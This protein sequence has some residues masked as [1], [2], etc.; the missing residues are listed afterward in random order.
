MDDHTTDMYLSE[1][2]ERL[3]ADAGDGPDWS[4][5]GAPA[6]GTSKTPGRRGGLLVGLAVGVVI[7]MTV[8]VVALSRTGGGTPV[9]ASA[10]EYVK[11]AWSQEAELACVGMDTHD[12]GGFDDATIEMWG[13]NA[14]GLVRIDAT[15]PDGMVERILLE[16]SVEE[17]RSEPLGTSHEGVGRS[18]T[19]FHVSACVT[20]DAD[21]TDS[22]SVAQSPM[23]H[24]GADLMAFVRVP[25]VDSVGSPFDAKQWLELG[26]ASEDGEWL[27]TPVT[28]Y[29]MSTTEDTELGGQT[30]RTSTTW[31]DPLRTRYERVFHDSRSETLG[32]VK[33]VVEV[34]ERK[35]VAESSVSFSA[36]ELFTNGEKPSTPT[37]TSTPDDSSTTTLPI[38]NPGLSLETSCGPVSLGSGQNP[39]LPTSVPDAD[40]AQ[41]IADAEVALGLE[42]AFFGAFEFFVAEQTPD[43][44]IL[45]AT[46]TADGALAYAYA[47]FTLRDGMW[48][49]SGWGG[50]HI[51]T[52]AEGWGTADWIL[53][54]AVELEPEP[55]QLAVLIQE[56]ACASGQAPIDREIVPVVVRSADRITVTVFVEPVQ[57]YAS[58][59]SNP[60]HPIT[61]DLDGPRDDLPIYNGRPTPNALV[62]PAR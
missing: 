53:D 29:T 38:D 31:F 55:K 25:S 23:A 51:E 18:D 26:G 30:R 48:A 16:Y 45:F 11:L 10:I 44:V 8:G 20:S 56:R 50:C 4:E 28:I 1:G 6:F 22:Y 46:G 9:A 59:P 61:I 13:P 40:V 60:W 3:T 39:V 21:G 33:W 42:G 47:T 34:V 36:E 19:V 14:D 5:L 49:P 15:A 32:S 52:T 62:V 35:T 54:S 43:S 7:V 57:G 27:G 58:C 12:N 17:G 24:Q 41:A 2:F 37:S